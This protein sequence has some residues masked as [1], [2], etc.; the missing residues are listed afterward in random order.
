MTERVQ[1]WRCIGC[2]KIESP[3]P[4]IGVCQDRKV[5]F[6]FAEEHD[7]LLAHA[8]ELHGLIGILAQSTP[9]EGEW[10]RSYR[11]LQERARK[12]LT[13]AP[14]PAASGEKVSAQRPID[15]RTILI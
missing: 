13:S 12:L 5:E 3:Q 6:V 11:S 4:C 15:G 2:G 7:R 10:E 14:F 9:R 8:N 1:A